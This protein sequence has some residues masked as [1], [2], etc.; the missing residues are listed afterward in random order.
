[1]K[2]M[3]IVLA[4]LLLLTG[5]GKSEPAS[6]VPEETTAT[7]ATSETSTESS[8]E[9]TTTTAASTSAETTATAAEETKETKETAKTEAA[10]TTAA[11]EDEAQS[12]ADVY[13]QILDTLWNEGTFP[14]GTEADIMGD[15]TGNQFAVFDIDGDGRDELLLDYETASM[16]GMVFFIWDADSNGNPYE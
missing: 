13:M 11:P 6:T 15:M 10:A 2:K 7:E 16:A 5:C 4:A 1:M 12:N 8:T 9:E 3:T 14:D